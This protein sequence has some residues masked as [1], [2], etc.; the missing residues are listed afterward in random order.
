MGYRAPWTRAFC[1]Y[2]HPQPPDWVKSPEK[3][4]RSH[5]A[6]QING[7]GA[8]STVCPHTNTGPV[9]WVKR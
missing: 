9:G 3:F 5:V 1:P 7:N 8:Y 2:T 6:Y 4:E